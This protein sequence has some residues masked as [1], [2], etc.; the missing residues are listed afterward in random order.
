[1]KVLHIILDAISPD[2]TFQMFDFMNEDYLKSY[3]S[4]KVYSTIDQR[5]NMLLSP[6]MWCRAYTQKELWEHSP[7]NNVDNER[8]DPTNENAEAKST[9]T[10]LNID[11]DKYLWNKVA[12]KNL[13]VFIFPY[14]SYS[15]RCKKVVIGSKNPDKIN[16]VF[17]SFENNRYYDLRDGEFY[18][19]S[20]D[21]QYHGM[22]ESAERFLHDD[23]ET[24]KIIRN[25]WDTSTQ[26]ELKNWVPE[27]I[28]E[29]KDYVVTN[30][31]HDIE[32][33]TNIMDEEVFP[34]ISHID[35]SNGGYCH[36]GLVETDSWMHFTQ[37]YDD[38]MTKIREYVNHVISKA[39]SVMD[40]DIV[41]M[42]GD[43]G[44]D[45]IRDKHRQ[46]LW[47]DCD[48]KGNTYRV[49]RA[50]WVRLPMYNDHSWSVGGWVFS[51]YENLL[52][53]FDEYFTEGK[54]YSQSEGF[55]MMDAV[56]DF[57]A[58]ETSKSVE[59]I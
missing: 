13:P 5:G 56:H 43:H 20:S 31:S 1:M 42:H 59:E 54:S 48:Y 2:N 6:Q 8:W 47:V 3:S 10:Y 28:D 7:K 14:Y 27:L 49:A 16:G 21:Y 51:K 15:V 44:Q 33:N 11:P 50:K 24:A 45:R 37:P 22:H 46:K 30:Y 39:I 29:V 55:L 17:R 58:N 53:K 25:K 19:K 38:L 9:I 57:I 4:R 40:P 35:W 32:D 36:I 26:E 23:P 12:S 41:I 34:N 52:N 18:R